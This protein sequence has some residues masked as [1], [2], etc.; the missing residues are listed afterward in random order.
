MSNPENPERRKKKSDYLCSV[1]ISLFNDNFD[2][3][4]TEPR[5]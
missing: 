3:V 5:G 4:C 2:R 1:E